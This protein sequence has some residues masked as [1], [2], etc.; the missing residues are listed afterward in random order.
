M[1]YLAI[2]DF[3]SGLDARKSPLTAPPGSLTRLVNAA[4]TPGGEIQ[5]RRAFVKVA[6][7]T[8]TKGLATV[9][10]KVVAFKDKASTV[11]APDLRM[12]DVTM[13]YHSIPSLS[14]TAKMTDYEVFDGSIYVTF[15]DGQ[16]KPNPVDRGA[17]LPTGIK[18]GA[19]YRQTSDGA[20]YTWTND[21]WYKWV[22]SHKGTPPF[23][24]RKSGDTFRNTKDNT[25]WKWNGS[26]WVV[27]TAGAT[28]YSGEEFPVDP[29]D[30][31]TFRDTADNSTKK[32]VAATKTWIPF[33]F[34]ATVAALPNGIKQF[35]TFHLTTDDKDYMWQGDAWVAWTPRPGDTNPHYF[36]DATKTDTTTP[37]YTYVKTEGSGKGYYI[38][39]YQSK[40][41]TLND[42][43]IW[44]SAIKYP[45]L[46]EEAPKVPPSGATVVSV[47]P[48]QGLAG[49]RVI[50]AAKK[51]I[52]TWTEPPTGATGAAAIYKWVES[53]P[54]QADLDWI[55][56]TTQR[57]GTGYINTALQESGGNGLQ[58]IEIY[59]DKLAVFSPETTQMWSMDPDPNQNALAQV[60]RNNGTLAPKSVQQFGSG[61]VLYLTHS[62][63]RSLKARDASNSAAVTDIGSP[64]DA[65]I[66]L[67]ADKFGRLYLANAQ[68]L[69]E[70]INGR[71][72]MVFPHQIL[73]LSYFP[74]PGIKAWSLYDTWSA[75]TD[76]TKYPDGRFVIDY[77]VTAGERV[78]IRS[79][80]D[81]F[82]FGGK[83]SNAY[84]NC[85]VEIRFPYL[86]A[87]KPGHLKQF[88]AID[89]TVEGTW[90]AKVSYNFDTN[91]LPFDSPGNL[92]NAEEALGTLDA[93]TWNRGRFAMQGYSS[94][95]SMRFYNTDDKPALLSNCAIH[96]SLADDEA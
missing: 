89:A 74:G 95:V 8:G 53:T 58:G 9:G 15:F 63:I 51:K 65:F 23:M 20:N 30:G 43:L 17:V 26:A 62:G 13:E 39:A 46:W 25:Y 18:Q 7:L 47:L 93:S 56:Q 19:Q 11:V 42:K 10:S 82:L 37:S 83:D 34:D 31:K 90:S 5:K 92:Q 57:T 60:L 69:T 59:Y 6:T 38:R 70:P 49:E 67:L 48:V 81:L 84:D 35:A 61:D 3:K 75:D 94:H 78:F 55:T 79:G 88:Q 52:Y 16:Y 40:M 85:G 33:P 87:G 50:L 64:V 29:V 21:S 32:Y 96:Y 76:L 71:F 80:D 77:I 2:D 12:S 45:L 72:W 54:S 1:P 22:E 36:Y 14:P 24:E 28:T 4:I 27:S 41:Y 91:G 73:V 68:A 86:D 66:K 44:F